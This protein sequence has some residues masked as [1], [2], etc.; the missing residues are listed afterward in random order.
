LDCFGAAAVVKQGAHS[1]SWKTK[2]V[3]PGEVCAEDEGRVVR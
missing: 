2:G 1:S 3:C